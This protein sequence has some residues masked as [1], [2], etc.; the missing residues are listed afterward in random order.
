MAQHERLKRPPLERQEPD[1]A[2]SRLFTGKAEPVAKA[3][4]DQS[5]PGSSADPIAHG[6]ALGYQVID[7]YL[8][9][10]QNAA[11]K[12][13]VRPPQEL[14]ALAERAS[15]R[16][17]HY[18]TDFAVAWLDYLQAASRTVPS[19]ASSVSGE[20]P[21][22]PFDL[23]VA[24][25][26]ARAVGQQAAPSTPFSPAEG[27]P[28]ALCVALH[29]SRPAEVSVDVKPGA[30]LLKLHAHD[31]RPGLDTTSRIGGV[32]LETDPGA[33]RI[34]VRIVVHDDIPPGVYAGLIVDAE[35]NLPRGSLCVRIVG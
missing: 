10:G 22:P 12:A 24:S 29:C 35:Q 30:L 15:E 32:V 13:T 18:A 33:N 9:L 3:D 2:F 25:T 8:A 4:V 5:P 26:P 21:I 16:M 34:T 28:A 31:L 27:A 11:R 17:V 19:A 20:V 7:E 1:R 14:S 23:G 6:V